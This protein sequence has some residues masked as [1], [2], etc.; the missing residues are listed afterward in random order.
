MSTVAY[1]YD[2]KAIRESLLDMITNLSTTETQF[3]SSLKKGPKAN[4]VYHEW[5]IDSLA[6]PAVN[7]QVEN[8]TVSSDTVT[9]PERLFNYCQISKKSAT[10]SGSEK[11]TDQAGFK[12]RMSYEIVKK[13]KELKNDM[14]LALIRGTLACGTGSAARSLRGLKASLSLVTSQSGVSLTEKMLNDY[15]QLVWDNAATEVTAIYCPMYIKRKIAGFTGAATAKN[16]NVDSKELVNVVE[17]YQ[18]DAAKN[19]K[20]YPH[21]YVTISG[22]TNY[23]VVG[24]AEEYFE[25]AYKREPEQYDI[26]KTTDGDTKCIVTEYT[27]VNKHYNVGFLAREVL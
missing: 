16:V 24:V 3:V 17:Y 10:V 11:S 22:D 7:A 14:E 23:D 13:M 8:F 20:L 2:D 6:S 18:A 26:A 9:N 21:R 5:L 15:L 4:G 12:D 1:T 27:L 19:V 25:I